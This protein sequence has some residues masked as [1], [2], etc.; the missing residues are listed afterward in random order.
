[1][2]DVAQAVEVAAADSSVQLVMSKLEQFCSGLGMKVEQFFPY[3][4]KQQEVI[5]YMGLVQTMMTIVLSLICIFLFYKA[6]KG[7]MNSGHHFN[8][9]KHGS[10]A[11]ASVIMIVTGVAGIIFLVASIILIIDFPSLLSRLLN[12]EFYAVR[13]AMEMAGNLFK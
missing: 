4:I 7:A 8:P 6:L 3:L 11:V 9:E 2:A 12:P 10:D 1:M 13:Q 5:F